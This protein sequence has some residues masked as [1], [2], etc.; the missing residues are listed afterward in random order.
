MPAG[1][2]GGPEMWTAADRERYGRAGLRYPSD[3]T[4]GEWALIAPLIRPAKRG[5]RRRSVVVREV[6]DGLLYVP[7]TGCQ[8]RH[9]PRDLPPRSTAAGHLQRVDRD[10]TLGA[11]HH[12]LSVAW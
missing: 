5:G 7:E 12:P 10:G 6:M 8:W 1:G 4:D 3:L 11:G 9:L 2:G